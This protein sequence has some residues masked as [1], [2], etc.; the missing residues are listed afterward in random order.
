MIHWFLSWSIRWKL[1]FGFFAVTMLTTLFNR[2]LA[3]VELQEMIDI[4][5]QPEVPAEILAALE[6]KRNAFIFNS[7]W[8][9][10][11]E[12]SL[13]F[14]IIGIVASLFVRPLREMG[15]ALKAADEGDLTTEV[16]MRSFDEI[17]DLE[18]GFNSMLRHLNDVIRNVDQ[19]GK[20]MAQYAFQISS[21]S[22][23][24]AEAGHEEQHRSEEVANVTDGLLGISEEVHGISTKTIECVQKTAVMAQKGIDSV[25]CNVSVMEKTAGDVHQAQ[26]D[27]HELVQT[28]ERIGTITTTISSIAAKT[29]LLALNAAIEAARAGEQG[30]GFAVVAEEVRDLANNTTES[31][32]EISEIIG[33]LTN[34]ITLAAQTM[35]AI[36]EKVEQS[37]VSVAQISQMFESMVS[38]ITRIAGGNQKIADA[39]GDQLGQINTLKVSLQQLF[40]AMDE[41]ADKAENT[42]NIGD[43][44][45][46]ITERLDDLLS[47]FQYKHEVIA[48]SKEQDKR[49]TPRLE[50]KLVVKV[51]QGDQVIDGLCNDISVT[52]IQLLLPTSLESIDNQLGIEVHLPYDNMSDYHSQTPLKVIG[53]ISWDKHVGEISKY[54]VEFVQLSHSQIQQIENS[55]QYFGYQ[56]QYVD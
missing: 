32:A 37:Q 25:A 36:V 10:A 50:Q 35:N 54:G 11:I 9:S 42:A 1:Q 12:L 51:T 17:G 43:A 16:T 7:Y 22:H 4:A 41:N 34:R 28:T 40:S 33:V 14:L 23:R 20:E 19:S 49:Q 6:D 8:E 46:T 15:Q 31:V 30:R 56:P 21:I 45:Y 52:G 13:L 47:S 3:T 48:R 44:L 5:R 53:K 38:D 29:N 39:S 55:F 24:I 27:F 2:W 18:E 26:A